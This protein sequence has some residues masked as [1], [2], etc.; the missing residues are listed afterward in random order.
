MM[1][2]FGAVP[3]KRHLVDSQS[4]LKLGV[5]RP[6]PRRV[7]RAPSGGRNRWRYSLSCWRVLCRYDH[8][9]PP[10]ISLRKVIGFDLLLPL[11]RVL[12]LGSCSASVLIPAGGLGGAR[13]GWVR[14]RF[15]G[16]TVEVTRSV[17][18]RTTRDRG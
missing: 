16:R 18:L 15:A 2:M 4:I 17:P 11:G 5:D 7:R 14:F 1:R 10:W 6:S 9:N 13:C 3:T 12:R 8:V